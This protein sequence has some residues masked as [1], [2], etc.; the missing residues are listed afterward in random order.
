MHVD[1]DHIDAAAP[2]PIGRRLGNATFVWA[3][4]AILLLLTNVLG[5]A[6]AL[7]F[8]AILLSDVHVL[9]FYLPFVLASVPTIVHWVTAVRGGFRGEL[10][11]V[12][13]GLLPITL[14]GLV[15]EWFLLAVIAGGLG[16]AD[17]ERFI[18][19]EVWFVD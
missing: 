18:R 14:I 15:M 12:H 11:P 5:G 3:M 10:H 16:P 6:Y 2:D 1:L 17:V 19:S 4:V 7:A 8:V 9:L 13:Y